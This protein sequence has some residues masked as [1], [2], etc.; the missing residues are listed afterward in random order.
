MEEVRTV[1]GIWSVWNRGGGSVNRE[2]GIYIYIYLYLYLHLCLYLYLYLYVHGSY[3][4]SACS[5]SSL[6]VY[7]MSNSAM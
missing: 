2:P 5:M 1:T 7:S 4:D 6:V 3:M